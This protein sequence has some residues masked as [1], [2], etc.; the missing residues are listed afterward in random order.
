[1]MMQKL[2]QQSN[3]LQ[4]SALSLAHSYQLALAWLQLNADRC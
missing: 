3:K 4:R 1:M 2:A